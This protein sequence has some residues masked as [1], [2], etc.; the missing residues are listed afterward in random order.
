MRESFLHFVWQF[1]KFSTLE[2]KS[3]TGSFVQ[4]FSIGQYN[5]HAGPD[6]LNAKILI[7]DIIW[8]G[9]VEIHLNSSDWDR[10]AHQNDPAYDNVILHVVW[11]HDQEVIRNN[12]EHVQVI[13]LKSRIDSN[14]LD[15]CNELLN[16]PQRTPCE[17][18]IHQVNR[19][20]RISMV[21]S[22]GVIRLE[23]KSL[24]I[25][26]RLEENQGSWEET[27]YQLLA[28][29][30]G[31]KRNDDPFEK[32]SKAI[33]HKVLIKHS[34]N[35]QEL[36]A[37]LFGM[38]GFLS[39][40]MSSV[41]AKELI[42]SFRFLSK[43]YG[44]GDRA[45]LKVEWKFLRM[46]PANFPTVRLSQFASFLHQNQKFFDTFIRFTKKEEL[47]KMFLIKPSAY[48][49]EH[50]DFGKKGRRKNTGMGRSSI[51]IILINTVVP[52]L[53]AYAQHTMNDSFMEKAVDL[54]QSLKAEKN[55]I[56]SDW[57]E[58]GIKSKNAF[59]TQALIQLHNEYCLKKRCLSC[60]IGMNLINR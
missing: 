55:H 37:L 39:D 33:P 22:T 42:Q 18:L 2:L 1:Q 38:A 40:Q 26:K 5:T 10:H 21:E 11:N 13:E 24:L 30:F 56:I 4:V 36:E 8:Y 57:A 16:S 19:L 17:G 53:A 23:Q 41:Y 14:L 44:I 25:L 51:D 3:A 58:L 46:R 7:D 9:H 29:N 48:W 43:K 27:T 50:Y 54:L 47:I 60:K 59:D 34:I 31:F 20:D 6:F 49:Q 52:L 15:R 12:G 32:L 35:L 28:R 45:L